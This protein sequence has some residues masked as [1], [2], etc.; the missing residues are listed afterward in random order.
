MRKLK[1]GL[2]ALHVESFEM[3]TAEPVRGTVLGLSYPNGCH[4]PPDS[5]DADTCQYATC[6]GTT[7]WYSCNG[8]CDCGATVGCQPES[9]GPTLCFG[10][11]S[12]INQ[13]H[14][15]PGF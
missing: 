15:T 12:C 9:A 10:M 3:L 11:P 2:E 6:A 5:L 13:C 8:T 7:C 4:T 14:P 1:L